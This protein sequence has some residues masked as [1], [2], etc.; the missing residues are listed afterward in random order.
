MFLTYVICTLTIIQI[1]NFSAFYINRYGRNGLRDHIFIFINMYL[2]YFMADGIRVYWQSHFNRYNVA[3]L[4]ILL[5]IGLQYLIEMK[6][7][8]NA[9]WELAQ[10][11]RTICERK[12]KV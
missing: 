3:W 4:F 9:P 11:K 5:N 10:I 8:K 6:N 7:H 1:W 12:T 2:L